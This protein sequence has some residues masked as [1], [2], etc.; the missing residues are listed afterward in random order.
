MKI[1]NIAFLLLLGTA[2]SS[3]PNTAY[4]PTFSADN[5][6]I[7]T[8]VPYT[9]S[10]PDYSILQ[11]SIQRKNERENAANNSLNALL[12][13]CLNLV[14][15][16]PESEKDWFLSYTNPIIESI[17]EQILLGNHQS[18]I[19][20]SNN[21]ILKFNSDK[22]ITYRIDSYN[23][24]LKQL[25]YKGSS[26]KIGKADKAALEYWLFKNQFKFSPKY[27]NG[28]L[29]GYY[30]CDVSW[31]QES[32]NFDE[33][34]KFITAQG[35]EKNNIDKLWD[36]YFTDPSKYASLVQDFEIKKF[37]LDQ[38]LSRLKEPGLSAEERDNIYNKITKMKK[39]LLDSNGTLSL[40]AYIKNLKILFSSN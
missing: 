34:Y 38:S 26:Y 29:I 28:E 35:K 7:F 30:P 10:T 13:W 11:N 40:D 21:A 1:K 6:T 27:R 19:Q 36:I 17:T 8:P 12:E 25:E 24:Y 39:L 31:L 5:Q 37:R 4:T 22:Q 20:M 14:N 16:I 23:D 9:P 18:A 32:L 2:L 33:L 15:Q 3:F